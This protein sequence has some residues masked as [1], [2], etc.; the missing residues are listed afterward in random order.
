MTLRQLDIKVGDDKLDVVMT[1]AAMA[2]AAGASSLGGGIGARVLIDPDVVRTT[3]NLAVCLELL[4]QR[5]TEGTWPPGGE[6]LALGIWRSGKWDDAGY[7][8][9]GDRWKDD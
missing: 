8:I 4:R 2:L 3:V 6:K 9:D 5:I 1:G 7:W